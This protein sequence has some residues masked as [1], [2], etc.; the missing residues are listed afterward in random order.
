MASVTFDTYLHSEKSP[1]PFIRLRSRREVC[2]CGR[3][4]VQQEP[5]EAERRPER[6]KFEGQWRTLLYI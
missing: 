4:V 5:A 1:E 6:P 2:S 3:V